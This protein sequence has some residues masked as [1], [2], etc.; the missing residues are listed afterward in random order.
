M[1][2]HVKQITEALRI[3]RM[4]QVIDRTGMSRST[5]YEKIAEGIFPRQ[6]CLSA[7]SVG[8]VESEIND[9][10]SHRIAQRKAA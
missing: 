10:I 7:R 6:V 5:I 2:E 9:W 8:F 4:K 3:L 1:A